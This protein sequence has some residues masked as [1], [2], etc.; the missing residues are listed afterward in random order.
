MA[1][2]IGKRILGALRNAIVSD[3]IDAE[4]LHEFQKYTPGYGGEHVVG[5]DSTKHKHPLP[6]TRAARRG[7][8][9][10]EYTMNLVNGWRLVENPGGSSQIAVITNV[11]KYAQYVEFGWISTRGVVVPGHRMIESAV[12]RG[13]VRKLYAEA[14]NKAL[15][16]SLATAEFKIKTGQYKKLRRLSVPMR[17]RDGGT[18][19]WVKTGVKSK[20]TPGRGVSSQVLGRIANNFGD[21]IVAAF[22]GGK[23][24]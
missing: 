14:A 5:L 1:A 2:D 9:P 18:L 6:R 22:N 13:R 23:I 15:L 17:G 4:L 20:G 16:I 19:R 12:N 7:Y 21:Y 10:Y 3:G 11:M 8:P 24:K